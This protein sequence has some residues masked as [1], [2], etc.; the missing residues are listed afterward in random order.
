MLVISLYKLKVHQLTL[1]SVIQLLQ[2]VTSFPHFGQEKSINIY[3]STI[4]KDTV[5]VL[6]YY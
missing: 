6:N 5:Y 1:K 3:H 4:T 2:K